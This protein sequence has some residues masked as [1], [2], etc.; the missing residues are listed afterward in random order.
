VDT[1]PFTTPLP[2]GP[3]NG[4]RSP[5][6]VDS[7]H[8]YSPRDNDRETT[9]YLSAAT[10]FSL[11]YAR[12]VV[13]RVIHEPYRALA[14]AYGA[15]VAVVARW[16]LDSL[17]RMALRDALLTLTFV[18]GGILCWLCS[19]LLLPAL[20]WTAIAIFVTLT[21]AFIIIVYERWI[22][23]YRV[24]GQQM[25]WD[26]FDPAAAPM[27]AEARVNQRLQAVADRRNGNL[28]VFRAHTAFAG[29]GRRLGREQLVI[30]VNRGKPGKDGTPTEPKPFTNAEVHAALLT[31]VKRIK[32]RDVQ[33]GERVY[34]N[35]RHIRG[36][37]ELQRQ[38]LEPPFSSVSDDLVLKAAEH[39]T[40]DARAYV[41]A[42]MHGWQGQLV[43][44]MFAR[45]VHTGGWLYIEYSFYSIPP[46]EW[47]YMLVDSLHEEP[48][49]RRLRKTF[50]WGLRRTVPTLIVS[51]FA[52]VGQ[53]IERL[54]WRAKET[55]QAYSIV[56]GQA[57]DYGALRSIREDAS[58]VNRQ[59]YFLARDEIMYLLLLQKSLL[60]EVENFLDEHNVELEEFKEQAK[61]IIDASNKNYSLHVGTVSNSTFA[62]GE[63]A[64]ATSAEG[65]TGAAGKSADHE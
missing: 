61:I 51:P 19:A 20:L 56:H 23:L 4:H 16:A 18:A 17:R 31:A 29:S 7:L 63:N 36:N 47:Q 12:I 46:I 27:P 39:P 55:S 44:T 32:L 52:L 21:A 59:H 43:V 50:M 13:R 41:C 58:G 35:G 6:G 38:P 62:F 34:V 60:R 33:A 14:P 28:V 11:E 30:N 53:G 2:S 40:P 5:A 22:R 42:E 54:K 37:Q 64:K 24:L 48:L 15:D 26:S 49:A 8:Y 57:F 9:R 3:G 25:R 10:Q 1:R 65:K 45:A